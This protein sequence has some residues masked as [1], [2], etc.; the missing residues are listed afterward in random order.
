MNDVMLPA[1]PAAELARPAAE[2]AT[3]RTADPVR[4]IAGLHPSA[5]A[6]QALGLESGLIWARARPPFPADLWR[7]ETDGADPQDHEAACLRAWHRP[8]FCLRVRIARYAAHEDRPSLVSEAVIGTRQTIAELEASLY[9]VAGLLLRAA[10]S[11]TP[12]PPVACAPPVPTSRAAIRLR[13]VLRQFGHRQAARLLTEEWSI[14]SAARSAGDIITH[15]LPAAI[16][17][18]PLPAGTYLADPFPWPG[19][20]IVLAEQMPLAGGVGRIIALAPDHAGVLRPHA[21]LLSDGAHHSYPCSHVIDGQVYLLPEDTGMGRTTLYRLHADAGLEPVSSI[22]PDR[23]LA[24]P[25]L[26]S[27]GGRLWIAATDLA[28]GLH[29]NLCLFHAT[30]PAGPW[31]PH[32]RDPVRIDIRNARPAGKPFHHDG[33]LFRPAQDCAAT[34]GAAVSINRIDTLNPDQFSEHPVRVLR[35]DAQGPYRHGLHTLS[36]A[37]DRVLVDGKRLVL[38]PRLLLNKI[39]RRFAGARH[40]R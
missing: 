11:G 17:W 8:P 21:T 3:I 36:C 38:R 25:T 40:V 27:H 4:V 31:F 16:A 22:A 2:R 39:Q 18:A 5:A 37:G 6:L 19:T 35:P 1:E 26:F 28:V 12:H 15:G 20:N 14:G 9:H 10:L 29:D 13:G 7:I 24:D 23:R 30:G 32:R 34:Y 33:A